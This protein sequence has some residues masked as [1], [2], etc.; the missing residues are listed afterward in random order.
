MSTN[1]KSKTISP[2]VG[3][4][5]TKKFYTDTRGGRILNVSNNGKKILVGYFN[6]P[7]DYKK[8]YTKADELPKN[9]ETEWWSLRKSGHWRAVGSPDNYGQNILWL[10]HA[11]YYYDREF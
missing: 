6:A 1:M 2:T 8:E 4:L 9:C 11:R 3:M 5:V 7:N 10:G